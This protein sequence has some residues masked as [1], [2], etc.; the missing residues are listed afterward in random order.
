MRSE[1]SP[2]SPAPGS[3]SFL[4]RMLSVSWDSFERDF[5]NTE[6]NECG[7]HACIQTYLSFLLFLKNIYLFGWS[8]LN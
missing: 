6:M 3:P 7:R 8:G 4:L 2:P 1:Q 5:I